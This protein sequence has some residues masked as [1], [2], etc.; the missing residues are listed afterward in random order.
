[1]WVIHVPVPAGWS[2]VVRVRRRL[3]LETFRLCNVATRVAVTRPDGVRESVVTERVVERHD[4]RDDGKHNDTQR[5]AVPGNGRHTQLFHQKH[6][7]R[8]HQH[9][10]QVP[11]DEPHEGGQQQVRD[12]PLE[13]TAEAV[14]YIGEDID[15][16][17]EHEQPRRHHGR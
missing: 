1:M 9:R 15:E 5:H 4:E 2:V 12:V 14:E 16:T 7:Y 10:P 17:G 11:E 8:A 3:Q 6:S 13:Q